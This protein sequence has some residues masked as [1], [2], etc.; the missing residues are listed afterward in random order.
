MTQDECQSG[1]GQ[2]AAQV[3][4]RQALDRQ[5]ELRD[6]RGSQAGQVHRKPEDTSE[7]C[8]ARAEADSAQA[9]ESPSDQMRLRLQNS[10][11]CW[12]ARARL[13]DRLESGREKG[14]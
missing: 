7:G 8:R 12:S 1:D 14:L 6:P 2:F 11:E 9:A 5:E 10:A 3:R 13:L 4:A